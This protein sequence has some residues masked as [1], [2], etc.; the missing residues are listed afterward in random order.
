MGTE[1]ISH[2][3]LVTKLAYLHH[4][5]NAPCSGCQPV[6]RPVKGLEEEGRFDNERKSGRRKGGGEGRSL[7]SHNLTVKVVRMIELD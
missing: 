4:L 2:H 3:G 5:V 7:L 6:S 1:P